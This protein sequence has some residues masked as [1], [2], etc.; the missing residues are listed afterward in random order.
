[1]LLVVSLTLGVDEDVIEVDGDFAFSNQ[2]GEDIVHHV[3]KRS[4]RVGHA[5]EHHSG[6]KESSIRYKG[7]LVLVTFL[8]AD[9]VVSPSDVKFSEE[10]GAF[11][12]VHEFGDQRKWIAILDR[13]LVELTVILHWTKFAVLLFDEEEG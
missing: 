11:Q 7:C 10:L 12:T 5:E 6:F 2:V 4:G 3:L 9:I 13:D 8:D 1:M